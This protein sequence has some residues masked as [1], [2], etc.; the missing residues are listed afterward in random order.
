[1]RVVAPSCLADTVAARRDRRRSR[2]GREAPG[3]GAWDTTAGRLG[4]FRAG[5]VSIR[6]LMTGNA[7]RRAHLW[8]FAQME[9]LLLV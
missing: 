1:M 4:D 7:D 8:S 2:T 9:E 3:S 5:G 6:D